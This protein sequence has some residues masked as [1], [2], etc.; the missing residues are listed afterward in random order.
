MAGDVVAGGLTVIH[1]SHYSLPWG[2]MTVLNHPTFE[3]A[4]ERWSGVRELR[5]HHMLVD[6]VLEMVLGFNRKG[7][8]KGCLPVAL[9]H[10][11][12]D[13]FIHCKAV[14]CRRLW[15]RVVFDRWS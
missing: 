2:M 14:V 13:D 7:N 3:E 6:V 15:C 12:Q 10:H 4:T 1:S 5:Q 9:G 11:P 8:T